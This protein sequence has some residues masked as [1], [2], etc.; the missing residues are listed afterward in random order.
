MLLER[1][2][3]LVRVQFEVAHDLTEH[4]PLD[5]GECQ[6]DMLVRQQGVIA[7]PR[8]IEGA[9]DDP[10]CGLGQLVLGNIEVL[11]DPPPARAALR[12]R[13]V[14]CARRQLAAG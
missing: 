1:L 13:R 14:R 9:V 6:A 5:V 12:P 7:A 2:E 11:H 4:V 10:F 3:D 8:F